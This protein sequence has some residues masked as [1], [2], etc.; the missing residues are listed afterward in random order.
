MELQLV[1]D[2]TDYHNWLGNLVRAVFHN[3][4]EPMPQD[5]K[6]LLLNLDVDAVQE[7][8]QAAIN[9]GLVK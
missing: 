1:V 8:M 7:H 9:L 5:L 4:N 3:P 6:D 2:N